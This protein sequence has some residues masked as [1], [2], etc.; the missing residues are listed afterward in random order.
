ML[1]YTR[2]I[3]KRVCCLPISYYTEFSLIKR[4]FCLVVHEVYSIYLKV[5][6]F[7]IWYL[8]A[9]YIILVLTT[10]LIQTKNK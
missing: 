3:E 5:F 6:K 10:T 1:T 2:K 7:D 9:L 8:Q 4:I